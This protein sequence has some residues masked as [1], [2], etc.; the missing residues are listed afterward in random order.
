MTSKKIMTKNDDSDI[1]KEPLFFF[2]YK[3][4]IFIKKAK[5]PTN[6]QNPQKPINPKLRKE[7]P[8]KITKRTQ[9]NPQENKL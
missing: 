8:K 4:E 7:N 9:Q 5:L 3:K 1:I 2:F 6:K